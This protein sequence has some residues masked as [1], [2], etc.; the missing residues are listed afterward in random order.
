VESVNVVKER[1]DENFFMA[2]EKEVCLMKLKM[3][4]GLN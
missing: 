2:L 3:K 4:V 1:M